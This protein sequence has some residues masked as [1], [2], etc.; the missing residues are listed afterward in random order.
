MYES[1][2]CGFGRTT[3]TEIMARLR[4]QWTLF[5]VVVDTQ[6]NF[7][8]RCLRPNVKRTSVNLDR[9]MPHLRECSMIAAEHED[10]PDYVKNSSE[11]TYPYYS[12]LQSACAYAWQDHTEATTE[13]IQKLRGAE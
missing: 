1:D 3:M 12:C 13:Y 6:R 10:C 8:L 9:T 5:V 4:F 7:L 2:I 11:Y